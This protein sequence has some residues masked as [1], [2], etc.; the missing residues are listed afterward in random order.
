MTNTAEGDATCTYLTNPSAAAFDA[1]WNII[2]DL[3]SKTGLG[4]LQDYRDRM[5][6]CGFLDDLAN[7]A[8]YRI[9]EY[10]VIADEGDGIRRLR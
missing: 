7:Q 10:G 1:A 6:K 5:L 9:A 4:S 3:T 8:L 2:R